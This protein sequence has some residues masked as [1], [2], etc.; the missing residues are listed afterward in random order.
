MPLSAN[1]MENLREEL[2]DLLLQVVYYAQMA[3]EEG[4]FDFADVVETVTTKNDSSSPPRVLAMKKPVIAGMAKG[5]WER[6]KAIEKVE[7]SRAPAK[8][9]ACPPVRD[10][11][12]LLD[13]VPAA[14]PPVLEAV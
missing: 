10:R 6:I 12:S 1:D 4:T 7:K 8:F 11:N 2:G 14:M 9:W 13:D 5:A 3:S